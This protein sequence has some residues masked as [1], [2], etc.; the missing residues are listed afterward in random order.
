[1]GRAT[2]VSLLAAAVFAAPAAA[3]SWLQ[4]GVVDTTEAIGNPARFSETMETLQPQIVRVNLYWGGTLG[5][6]RERPKNGT[7]PE[8]DAYEWGR[9]DLAVRTAAARGV[10][11]AFTIFGTPWW[12]NGGQPQNRAPQNM[13]RL[14]EFAYAAAFRYSG[15]YRRDDGVILPR[16]SLWIA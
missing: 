11:V 6:A 1:M 2:L 16:V 12:A 9:Y 5:V 7:N 10:K 4:L 8:D 15:H 3:S 13:Q 14:K